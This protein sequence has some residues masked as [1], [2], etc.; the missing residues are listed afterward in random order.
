MFKNITSIAWILQ[1]ICKI[2]KDFD[3]YFKNIKNLF[4]TRKYIIHF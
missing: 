1:P 4:L 3:L 2:P